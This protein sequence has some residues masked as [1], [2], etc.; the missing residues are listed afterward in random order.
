MMNYIDQLCEDVKRVFVDNKDELFRM[1]PLEDQSGSERK[2]YVYEWYTKDKGK[3]FYVGKGTGK[4]YNHIITDM[5][6]GRGYDYRILQMDFGIDYRIVK[7]NLTEQEALIYEKYQIYL[8]ESQGEVLLQF[9]DAHSMWIG[10]EDEIKKLNQMIE[11]SIWIDPF[12]RRYYDIEQGSI[13]YDTVND[14]CLQRV[15]FKQ[16]WNSIKEERI[17]NTVTE[18][19]TSIGGKIYKSKCKAVETIIDFG[20]TPYSTYIALKKD[21]YQVLN[22]IQVFNYINGI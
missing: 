11:P 3:V 9:I 10:L 12:Y 7:D 4:R 16:N 8:R 13:S 20:V 19:I 15:F 18:Y 21:E 22:C 14:N 1:V 6:R 5:E 2:Y 17:I